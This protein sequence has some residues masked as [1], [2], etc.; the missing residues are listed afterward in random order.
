MRSSMMSDCPKSGRELARDRTKGGLVLAWIA[1]IMSLWVSWKPQDF[2][3]CNFKKNQVMTEECTLANSLLPLCNS[4]SRKDQDRL[5]SL[6]ESAQ[7]LSPWW[8]QCTGGVKVR[9][10]NATD[11]LAFLWVTARRR[12]FSERYPKSLISC[13]KAL[14]CSCIPQGACPLIS[15]D[16]A[17]PQ[18][19]EGTSCHWMRGLRAAGIFRMPSPQLWEL[20]MQLGFPGGG[21]LV[22]SLGHSHGLET[23]DLR[24]LEAELRSAASTPPVPRNVLVSKGI[25]NTSLLG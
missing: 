18:E 6:S 22:V 17:L 8:A 16:V 14:C 19:E 13:V 4:L 12:A 21:E 9:S 2:I 15:E 1:K 3:A 23:Q 11:G 24:K 25:C 20:G 5:T 10:L 7:E